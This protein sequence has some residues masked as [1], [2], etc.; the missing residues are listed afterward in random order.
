MPTNS[1]PPFGFSTTNLYNNPLNLSQQR[2]NR[3]RSGSLSYSEFS[4]S[5]PLDENAS[6]TIAST[7]ASLGLS[8]DDQ[9]PYFT[10]HR[11][12]TVNARAIE[13]VFNGGAFVVPHTFSP[14]LKQRPRAI[15]LGRSSDRP[16]GGE[17]SFAPFDMSYSNHHPDFSLDHPLRCSQLSH[18]FE[19]D[20]V[21]NDDDEKQDEDDNASLEPLAGTPSR[22][23]WLGNITPSLSIP[24]LHA[25]FAPYGHVESARILSDKECAFVN[26]ET[27]E[28]A[29]AAKEDL[30]NRLKCK[31]G[32]SVVKVGFGKADVTIAMALTNEAGPNAQ[33][34][35]R[36][37]WVGNIPA[38]IDTAVLKA[39]FQTYGKIE[40]IRILSHKN[41]GFINFERQEDAVK[42]RKHLQ[43]KEILGAGT[44]TVRIGFARAP[45]KEEEQQQQQEEAAEA[46]KASNNNNNSNNNSIS[47]KD[48]AVTDSKQRATVIMMASMMMDASRQNTTS[49]TDTSRTKTLA[50]E[51]KFMM[52]QL[53]Y[54][55]ALTEDERIPIEYYPVI[56]I[57]PELGASRKLSPLRLREIRK[58]LDNG[59]GISDIE[60]IAEEC[61]DDIIELCSD[62]IGNTIVQK[63]FE[64]CSEETKLIM[65]KRIAPY[66]ASIGVHKNG[67]WA[68]QKIIDSATTHEQ[69]EMICSHLAPF[70]P[71][72]LLDQFGNYVVQCCL[73]MGPERNQYVFDAIVDNCWEIGQGRFGARSVRAILENTIVTKDQ[74]IYVASAIMQNALLL[75]NNANG[76]ILLNW[77]IDTS[78]LLG[79]YRAD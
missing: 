78:G 38:N 21:G 64:F 74:Q 60:Y 35:T 3:A 14:A 4:S 50:S 16:P 22:A 2:P 42:A 39:I 71:L 43:N 19:E 52:Q 70:V 9:T 54:K 17:T 34:P 59:Q 12:Y 66:L 26:F 77:L 40:S 47:S 28:A 75:T 62:Y 29:V 56:P 23:L 31:I 57:V 44:G 72:L 32:S 7:M 13:P 63:L 41:C 24:D 5:S 58:S 20:I 53:G 67:T 33:G 76:S 25:L 69:V 73:S 37:L 45:T 36:A 10:R 11:A 55:G 8:D 65:M 15:S 27:V 1:V 6:N 61:M 46:Q 68:A 48:S 30:E 51:R 49:S 79:Q 18:R